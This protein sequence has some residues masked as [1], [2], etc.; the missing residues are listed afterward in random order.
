MSHPIWKIGLF[1]K[2]SR[3]K[4]QLIGSAGCIWRM[5]SSDFPSLQ[6]RLQ[7][8]CRCH[9][10]SFFIRKSNC[11]EFS[12]S[13]EQKLYVKCK[14]LY[15]TA[16]CKMFQPQDVAGKR[17]WLQE[18]QQFFAISLEILTQGLIQRRETLSMIY[19]NVSFQ[20]C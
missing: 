13:L 12:K 5:I 17:R 4:A 10:L 20:E 8:I 1:E 14:A 16:I 3:D 7:N 9:F 11:W 6:N 15:V 18:C 2:L 19:E